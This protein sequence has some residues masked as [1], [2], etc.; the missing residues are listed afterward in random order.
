MIR[1]AWIDYWRIAATFYITLYHTVLM[2]KSNGKTVSDVLELVS[3]KGYLGTS[4]FMVLSGFIITL[5]YKNKIGSLRENHRF[6]R[7]RFAR[8]APG[9]IL[10]VSA[11]VLKSYFIDRDWNLSLGDILDTIGNITLINSFL[12]N[13]QLYLPQAWTLGVLILFYAIFPYMCN[14]LEV[15]PKKK[16]INIALIT[17][18]A[19]LIIP[20]LYLLITNEGPVGPFYQEPVIFNYIH[21]FPLLRVVEPCLGMLTALYLTK[22]QKSEF[23]FHSYMYWISCLALGGFFFIPNETIFF[24]VLHNGLPIPLLLIILITRYRVSQYRI[25]ALAGQS[26]KTLADA[27]LGVYLSHMSLLAL[28]KHFSINNFPN[29]LSV[30]LSVI[31]V[32][33]MGLMMQSW[34][35]R[36]LGD[37][38]VKW[39]SRRRFD[40]N[41]AASIGD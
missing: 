5:I 40:S 22:Y 24:P 6:W 29:D 38:L 1:L 17:W 15:Y 34:V 27:T 11:V 20:I 30:F 2:F 12:P 37:R 8:V 25:E 14:K 18:V 31:L 4:F 36:P 21:T 41:T 39:M 13:A 35:F 10:L 19:Y 33:V 32:V 7:S 9:Y 16:L 28:L 3:G 26:V 23:K